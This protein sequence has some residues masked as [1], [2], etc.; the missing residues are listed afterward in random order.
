M[1]LEKQPTGSAAFRTQRAIVI[2][3][4]VMA[5]GAILFISYFHDQADR[6]RRVQVTV[7]RL[8]AE[9]DRI[10]A[11]EW[12]A[13]A[14]HGVSPEILRELEDSRTGFLQGLS[15]L[16]ENEP[17]DPATEPFVSLGEDYL[18]A[19]DRELGL[20]GAG[21]FEE[22]RIVDLEQAD[23]C[24]A[25]L[26]RAIEEMDKTRER[27]VEATSR[28]S[29]A[30]LMVAAMV[31]SSVLLLVFLRVQRVQCNAE[32]ILAQQKALQDAEQRFR[33][34]TEKSSDLTAITDE[35]GTIRYVS[36]SVMNILGVEDAALCGRQVMELAHEGDRATIRAALAAVAAGQEQERTQFRLQN[37]DGAWRQLE[38]AIRNPRNKADIGG[39]VLNLRDV[40]ARK[41]VEERLLYHSSYDELTQLPNRALF[42]ECLREAIYRQRRYPEQSAAVLLIDIDDF[43][44]INNSLGHVA[45]DE[46]LAE[47]GQRL[48]KCLRDRDTIFRA[49][50]EAEASST[51]AR[52]GGDEFTVL[53]EEM[54]EP[55]D[56][57]RVA[58]RIQEALQQPAELM[59]HRVHN[60]ASI[61]ISLVEGHV[62]AE[63]TLR[64]AHIAMS[65]AKMGGKGR[66]ELFD[67]TMHAQVVK[68]VQ[69]ESDVRRALE[70]DE[71]R[72]YYQPIVSLSPTT[73]GVAG[74]EALIR[75]ERPGVG[76]VAPGEFLAA[77]ESTGLMLRVGKWTLGEAC[78]QAAGWN[79]RRGPQPPLYIS[80]N[81]SVRQLYFPGFV[82]Q[83]K[84]VLEE[85]KLAAQ[86]LKLE[87]TEGVAMENAPRTQQILRRIKELGVQLSIDDFGTGYS[88]LSYLRR[89]PV[90]TLKIDR[91]FVTHMH[92]DK[93]SRAIV[94]TIIA[95]AKSLGLEVVAEGVE[96]P[97][98]LEEL[99]KAGCDAVQGYYF[100]RPLPAAKAGE[101]L[102][103]YR[104]ARVGG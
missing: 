64:N 60:T 82:Q 31:S 67:Q 73:P 100:A 8:S 5:F 9:A 58:Q 34:L 7:T 61:G 32:R 76:V 98:Q 87:L 27:E 44:T 90:D 93:E 85:S 59:N 17:N 29:K 21:R 10:Q 94:T 56:A 26:E 13:I 104:G 19:V 62:S 57:M 22:A 28:L 41:Q 96:L 91:S 52:L 84:D 16:R 99:R 101:F 66:C 46:L 24:F 38:G 69:L 39:L 48:R 47:L 95:L 45:G 78:R 103:G 40:T 20:I 42:M 18:K 55:S 79:P 74:F 81:V 65:R 51:V 11:R 37:A 1:S 43:K 25:R 89:F 12:E 15:Q 63:E 92:T 54:G 3:G 36:P 88:S 4:T 23:R 72:L 53:L 50:P 83:V 77:V 68:R 75:W 86:S 6:S 14:V 102:T 49:H 2:G 97:E 30:G 35:Q 33:T 80:V 71:F 70:R